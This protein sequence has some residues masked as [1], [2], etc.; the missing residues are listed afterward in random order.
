YR[1]QTGRFR[2]PRLAPAPAPLQYI[3]CCPTPLFSSAPKNANLQYGMGGDR[4][5]EA[6]R[7]SHPDSPA[8]C[9]ADLLIRPVALVEVRIE[10]SNHSL[11]GCQ[12]S[13]N[14]VLPFQGCRPR[15]WRTFHGS[16][17]TETWNAFG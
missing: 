3:I 17:E 10:Q 13:F 11:T 16:R 8:H 1:S 12:R 5:I 9:N 15:F 7:T 2:P 4:P 6:W 14:L